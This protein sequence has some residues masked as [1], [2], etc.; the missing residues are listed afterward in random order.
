[1]ADDLERVADKIG[2]RIAVKVSQEAADRGV[3]PMD[4]AEVFADVLWSAEMAK[5]VTSAESGEGQEHA[6]C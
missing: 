6:G 4:F 5:M 1:M 2:K 3:H